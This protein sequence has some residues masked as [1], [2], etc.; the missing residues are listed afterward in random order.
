MAKSKAAKRKRAEKAEAAH[1]LPKVSGNITPPPD[2]T[3]FEPK[4]LQTLVDEDELEITIDTLN[5]LSEYPGLIKSKTCKDLRVAVYNFRQACTTG[6]NTSADTNLTA[7]I[8]AALVDGKYTD[9]RILLSEMRIR[10]E[11]PKLGALC[12]WVRDLDVVSGLSMQ[13]EGVSHV[14]A[15]RSAK[16]KELLSVLDLVL[17]VTGPTDSNAL[18]SN[19]SSDPIALQAVWNMQNLCDPREAVY[20]RVLDKTIFE[21]HATSLAEKLRIIETTAGAQRKPPNHHP[22]ILYTSLDNTINLSSNSSPATKHLHPVVPS[23]ALIKDVLSPSECKQII[24]LGE[25]INFLP[26]APFK[27]GEDASILAHNFYWVIDQAFHDKLWR[28]VKEHVPE[29]VEGKKVR[30][31]NRRF[32]VYRYVPGA[33]YRCHID[34]AWPPSGI[35]PTTDKYI[36]DSSPRDAKQ[37]SL[38]TFLIYLNDEFEAGETTFFIP[39]VREGTMNAY[40]VRPVMGAVAMFPHGETRG[41]LLHEGTGVRRGANPIL[42]HSLAQPPCQLLISQ[43]PALPLSCATPCVAIH[44]RNVLLARHT[45]TS[46]NSRS[47]TADLRPAHRPICKHSLSRRKLAFTDSSSIS[48]ALDTLNLAT[49]PSIDVHP[50]LL[51][52]PYHPPVLHDLFLQQS[53][54]LIHALQHD[55]ILLYGLAAILIALVGKL[56]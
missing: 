12:R 27:E 52:H 3:S 47:I 44:H 32:R 9:A 7:R 43:R 22:A 20:K 53:Q 55:R 38:F 36:Y 8:T 24:A 48:A 29:R 35:E 10:D 11:A 31:L 45:L 19:L 37:S 18:G 40:P 50:L 46:I 13:P 33:E 5:L 16:D 56:L 6:V 49:A 25:A 4:N 23:L 34:G 26:D 41:A 30:G 17:R 28:R 2:G 42:A 14:L 51:L 15:E 39:S 54:P 1:K 21:G